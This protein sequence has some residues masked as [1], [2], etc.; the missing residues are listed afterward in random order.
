MMHKQS[1]E[2]VFELTSKLNKEGEELTKL[3]RQLS[4]ITAPGQGQAVT[5]A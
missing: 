4:Q 5:K 1:R 2:T 3:Q